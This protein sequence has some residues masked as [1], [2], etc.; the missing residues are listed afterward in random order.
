VGRGPDL[1]D[2]MRMRTTRAR[3]LARLHCIMYN[4]YSQRELAN[5][6]HCIWSSLHL[7]CVRMCVCVCLVCGYQKRRGRLFAQAVSL[8]MSPLC[9][10]FDLGK[11]PRLTTINLFPHKRKCNQGGVHVG[12]LAR[13]WCLLMRT[14][15][16]TRSGACRHGFERVVI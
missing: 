8:V 3:N 2:D 7:F 15:I 1:Y 4:A 10:L 9:P 11:Y 6:I 12:C 13:K 5:P 16:S 14:G